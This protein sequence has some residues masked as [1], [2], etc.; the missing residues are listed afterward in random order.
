[1]NLSIRRKIY[2]SFAL[3]VSLFMVNAVVT[4]TTLSRH[5]RLA[6]HYSNVIDPSLQSLY[7]L[8]RMVSESKMYMTSWVFLRSNQDKDSLLEIHRKRYAA[9]KADLTRYS[10]LWDEDQG[11]KG[12]QGRDSLRIVFTSFEQLLSVE[13]KVMASLKQVG[14]YDDPR[15]RLKAEQ[16]VGEEVLPR[17][18]VLTAQV[19]TIISVSQSIGRQATA[20]IVQSSARLQYLIVGFSITTLAMGLLLSSLMTRGIIRPVNKIRAIVNDL[21]K[22]IIRKVEAGKADDE[23]AEMF[24]S[25]GHL[26]E[27]LQVTAAFAHQVGMRRFDIP[28]APLSAGDTLGKALVSMRDNLKASDAELTAVTDD[29]KRKDALLQAVSAAAH[30]LVRGHDFDTA[31]GQA[32]R[33]LGLKAPVDAVN[34]FETTLMADGNWKARQVVRWTREEDKIEYE[35]P[36]L[37]HI[38][39]VQH[40]LAALSANHA[41]FGLVRDVQDKKLKDMLLARKVRSYAAIPVFIGE[42]FWGFVSVHVCSAERAW[43]AAESSILSSFCVTLGSAIERIRMEEQLVV[44]KEKAEAASIA[45]SE[46]MANMSHELRTPMNAIIGFTDLVLTGSGLQKAQRQYLQNVGKAAGN[47]MNIINDIL[48]FSKIEAGKLSID[49][50][51]FRLTEL[52][53][54]TVDVLSIK[55]REKRIQLIHHIDPRLPARFSGDQVRIRQILMNLIGNA[56]KFTTEGKIEISAQQQ[57]PGYDRDGSQYMDIAL[58]VRDTGIGIAPDKLE[59]IFESF[60]QADNSTTRKY[61]GTGLGLTISRS[62]A[63]LMNGSLVVESEVGKGSLFTVRLPLEVIDQRLPVPFPGTPVRAMNKFEGHIRALVAEDEPMNMLLIT[64][65]LEN[66]GLEVIE[67]SDGADAL[68]KLQQFDPAIVFMDVNMPG[69]DG[70]SATRKIRSLP[71]P[72]HRIPIIALT[73]DAMQED[74]ERCLEAGMNDFISKPF[75]L[76]ELESV[77]STHLKSRLQRK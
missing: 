8:R 70:Y 2:L 22:G 53:E 77:L 27:K 21:G 76:Q 7:A 12:A 36:D 33:L 25:V 1:M 38:C 39:G 66:M 47:L 55:A 49:G 46:F 31:V 3:L 11:R 30:E 42:R 64:K 16:Q 35:V 67:A 28:F 29:L 37:Q 75:R 44:A 59:Q 54:E 32:I 56:I 74:K 24:R 40:A 69:L 43:N 4:I 68:A 71:G 48:D 73:A 65:V 57:G 5:N 17:A 62:L 60:T 19:N 14:D 13:K 58:S 6:E 50:R 15:I 23:I 34:L 20:D 9:L 61:G 51:P 45:K 41:C 63:E 10:L 52:I 26:S 72:N 18:G